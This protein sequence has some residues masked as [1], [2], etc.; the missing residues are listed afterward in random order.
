MWK[1]SCHE[2]LPNSLSSSL[3]NALKATQIGPIL[4]PLHIFQWESHRIHPLL[5]PFRRQSYQASRQATKHIP[6]ISVAGSALAV[7]AVHSVHKLTHCVLIQAH[8]SASAELKRVQMQISQRQHQPYSFL[9]GTCQSSSQDGAKIGRYIRYTRINHGYTIYR[10]HTN[11]GLN[12]AA[13]Y[14]FSPDL[15]TMRGGGH[16]R[17]NI[18]NKCS[19]IAMIPGPLSSGFA[20]FVA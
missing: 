19:R 5:R 11:T 12:N 15:A 18:A 13:A 1:R 3:T 17:G 4:E 16:R 10:P 20:G 8:P 14:C 9:D 6:R 7:L 2:A